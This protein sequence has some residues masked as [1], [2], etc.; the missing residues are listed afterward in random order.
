MA[1]DQATE[2]LLGSFGHLL[3]ETTCLPH[4]LLI[5]VRVLHLGG[6]GSIV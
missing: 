5:D 4:F 3:R 2:L 1:D 6:F